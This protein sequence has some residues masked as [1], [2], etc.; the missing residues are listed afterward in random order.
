MFFFLFFCLIYIKC[1]RANVRKWLHSLLTSGACSC[2]L[3]YSLLC[4]AALKEK[5]P[6]FSSQINF[7]A[8]LFSF[9]HGREA[10][11]FLY[12]T[13]W[14]YSDVICAGSQCGKQQI[15][16]TRANSQPHLTPSPH[17]HTHTQ[18]QDTIFE[19]L[20]PSLTFSNS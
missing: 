4:L 1:S 7:F 9:S 19:T 14:W 15:A 17:T 11:V 12:K 3:F 6:L 8:L 18:T 16:A 10:A 5:T 20:I 2:V 13:Q